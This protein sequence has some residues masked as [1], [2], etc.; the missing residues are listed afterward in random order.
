MFGAG[1]D[2]GSPARQDALTELAF[3]VGRTELAKFV[4]LKSAVTAG[5]WRQAAAEVIDSAFA[6][7][8]PKRARDIANRLTTTEATTP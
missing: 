7:G 3:V 1:F 4:R 6:R 5:D 2:D 8:D